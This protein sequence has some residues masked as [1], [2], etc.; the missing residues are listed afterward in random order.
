[1][2]PPRSYVTEFTVYVKFGPDRGLWDAADFFRPY[3]EV[4]RGGGF[5]RIQ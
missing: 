2:S 3:F 5:G 1:M 4:N